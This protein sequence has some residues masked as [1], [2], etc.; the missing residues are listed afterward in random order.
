MVLKRSKID[1]FI[2]FVWELNTLCVLFGNTENNNYQERENMKPPVY[3]DDELDNK[4]LIGMKRVTFILIAMK[5]VYDKLSNNNLKMRFILAVLEVFKLENPTNDQIQE[6][7]LN[8]EVHAQSFKGISEPKAIISANYQIGKE[9]NKCGLDLIIDQII[10]YKTRIP[11]LNIRF[12]EV[13]NILTSVRKGEFRTIIDSDCAQYQELM[14]H[15]SEEL[16]SISREK[17]FFKSKVSEKK[18]VSNRQVEGID[19]LD[20]FKAPYNFAKDYAL[21][22]VL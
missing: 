21:Q 12:R 15:L 3:H 5:S 19:K 1:S 22:K 2:R 20:D 7:L 9:K 17:D 8:L 11:D 13:N 4:Q 16:D 18:V 6:R 14:T 10:L